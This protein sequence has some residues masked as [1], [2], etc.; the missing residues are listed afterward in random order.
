M[1]FADSLRRTAAPS[2]H[3]TMRGPGSG[4]GQRPVQVDQVAGMI[5]GHAQGRRGDARIGPVLRRQP[6]AGIDYPADQILA[7]GLALQDASRR[8]AQGLRLRGAE[9]P[10]VAGG[11]GGRRP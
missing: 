1:V 9:N 8:A 5:Q 2:R 10:V 3:S 4:Q 7:V 11:R 6:L